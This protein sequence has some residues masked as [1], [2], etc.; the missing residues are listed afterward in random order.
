MSKT[1]TAV[2]PQMTKLEI[3]H[4]L[5]T[6]GYMLDPNTKGY[7]KESSQ[8]QYRTDD[9]RRC[10]VGKAISNPHIT[11]VA[12]CTAEVGGLDNFVKHQ[13]GLPS[14]DSIM[15]KKYRGHHINF[16]SS[17]QGFHDAH[18]SE[19]GMTESGSYRYR[20]LLKAFAE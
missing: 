18:L 8:C 2:K 17:L 1:A 15:F 11:K 16:W 9:G 14:L 6:N 5:F 3:F 20:Q 12:T 4:E 10:A 13:M 7:D 19:N